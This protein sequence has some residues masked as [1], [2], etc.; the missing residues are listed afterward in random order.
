MTRRG[1]RRAASV[2]AGD[3]QPPLPW[4]Y[5]YV[6]LVTPLD[7]VKGTHPRGQRTEMAVGELTDPELAWLARIAVAEIERRRKTWHREST[8]G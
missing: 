4:R 1:G 3:F 6:R 5:L 8:S 7:A 2:F